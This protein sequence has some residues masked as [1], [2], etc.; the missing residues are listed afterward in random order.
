MARQIICL[1]LDG[2]IW[3]SRPWYRELIMQCGAPDPSEKL[4]KGISVA[5]MIR[6]HGLQNKF[7]SLCRSNG[8]TLKLYPQVIDVLDQLLSRGI[9]IS[10]VTNLPCWMA[11][12]MIDA[13]EL[14]DKFV[15]ILP[16]ERGASKAVRLAR[17]SNPSIDR[18]RHW[19]VGDEQNDSAAAR[20]ARF[21]FAWVTWGY[22][23]CPSDFDAVLDNFTE[24]LDL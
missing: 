11:V 16:W 13:C 5:G 20:E 7:G 17:L 8:D 9:Q 10:V 15:E 18:D 1:D 3:D 14:T 6:N 22:G 2:T 24:I 4:D 12:P 19:Y 21:R 23:E